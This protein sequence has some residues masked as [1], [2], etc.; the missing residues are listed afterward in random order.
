MVPRKCVFVVFS[1]AV[2]S[3]LLEDCHPVLGGAV[4]PQDLVEAEPGV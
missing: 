3:V 2:E 1:S 4:S